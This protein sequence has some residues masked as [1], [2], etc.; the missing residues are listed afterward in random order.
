MA[1][2]GHESVGAGT[3]GAWVARAE[4]TI[5]DTARRFAIATTEFDDFD[6]SGVKPG[7]RVHGGEP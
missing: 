1:R 7:E 6:K 4:P 5:R 3:A 2:L